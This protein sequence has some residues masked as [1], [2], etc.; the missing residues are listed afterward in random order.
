[1]EED[2]RILKALKLIEQAR[3]QIVDGPTCGKASRIWLSET[4]KTLGQALDALKQKS[5][6]EISK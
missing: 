1:M 5:V 4:N 2:E 3:R 6:E